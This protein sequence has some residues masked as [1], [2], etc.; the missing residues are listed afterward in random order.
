MGEREERAKRLGGVV[1]VVQSAAPGG[2][3]VM[4]TLPTV[5]G[6]MVQT[7][8]RLALSTG[9]ARPG[10][11]YVPEAGDEVLVTFEHGDTRRPVVI[12]SLWDDKDKPPTTAS[13]ARPKRPPR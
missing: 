2:N 12:G 13:K 7:R 10:A 1:G 3:F 9:S 5:S 8:A 6:N 4:I 11:A